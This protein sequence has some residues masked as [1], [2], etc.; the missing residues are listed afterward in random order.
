MSYIIWILN[1]KVILSNVSQICFGTV[2]RKVLNQSLNVASTKG[3]FEGHELEDSS[4]H[5]DLL[6]FDLSCIVA[7]TENFSPTNKLGQG[8]FGSVFKV[9]LVVSL[10]VARDNFL[11]KIL[12]LSLDFIKSFFFFFFLNSFII[13]FI[14]LSIC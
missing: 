3:F 10:C 5:S 9:Q 4:T 11:D 1:Y 8:G 12:F 14:I 7:A 13:F 2:K 6:I